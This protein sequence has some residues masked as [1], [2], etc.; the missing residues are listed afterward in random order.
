MSGEEG[1]RR[2]PP[3]GLSFDREGAIRRE[4]ENHVL[5]G[6]REPG[7]AAGAYDAALGALIIEYLDSLSPKDL[8]RVFLELRGESGVDEERF[9]GAH[10]DS[11]Q[12]RAELLAAA[13]EL[14]Q[15]GE[16]RRVRGGAKGAEDGIRWFP[17]PRARG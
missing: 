10:A 12:R 16:L 1:A 8:I 13:K 3:A 11:T 9:L 6:D 2:L 5:R 7:G 14:R 17:G 15:T 4:L